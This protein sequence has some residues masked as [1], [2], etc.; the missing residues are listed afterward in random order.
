[1]TN[2]E[3]LPATSTIKSTSAPSF[4]TNF[5]LQNNSTTTLSLFWIDTQGVERPYGT[6]Q[7]GASLY[8]ST[9]STHAWLVRDEKNTVLFKF[10]ASAS[11]LV[12]VSAS[13][14]TFQANLM[15][16]SGSD[17]IIGTSAD[18]R[19]EPG[20]GNDSINGGAGV[21]LVRLP[22]ISKDYEIKLNST[23]ES[24]LFSSGTFG[25]KT[26]S[27]VEY[28]QF[29]DDPYNRLDLNRLAPLLSYDV[30][31]LRKTG[32]SANR[33]DIVFVAEGYTAGQRQQFLA[34]AARMAESMLGQ[35]NSRL[36]GPFSAY[37]GLFNVTAIFVPSAQ[38]GVD[39]HLNGTLVDT[40]FD[41]RTYGTDGRLGYG[42]QSRVNFVLD[43]AVSI[44]GRDM[45]VV[46]MNTA[47]YTNAGG[48]SA[49]VSASNPGAYDL[50][51][52]E[53]GH[54]YA[55]LED[56]YVDA[57]LSQGPLPTVLNS[58][59]V[60]LSPTTVPWKLW[61]GYQDELGTIGAYEG[62]Y[63]RKTGVWRATLTSKMLATGQPFSAPQKEAF[64]E[65][66]Y[67][68][69]GDYLGLSFENS[70]S[71]SAVVPDLIPVGLEWQS[72]GRV[73]GVGSMLDAKAL[74]SSGS[75][76]LQTPLPV[77]VTLSSKDASGMI[78]DPGILVSTYQTETIDVLLGG[79]DNDKFY[80]T[81]KSD[82][83]VA[84]E[85]DDN[86][87]GLSGDDVLYGND[88][89]D[90]LSGG[91]GNDTL[92]GGAGTDTALYTGP[93]ANY[94]LA[95]LAVG[96]SIFSK[97]EGLDTL[98]SIERLK[99]FDCSLA[100]D[101]GVPQSAGETA[102]LIGAVL[103]GKLALDVSKQALLGSV[104]GLFD[105]GYSM[106]TLAGAL[107]RLDIWSILTGQP[108]KTAA[109]T[110]A[111]DTAIVKY[112]LSNVYGLVADEATVKANA[113]VMHNEAS[114]GAWLAQLAQSN[115]GQSHI[116]LMGLASTGLVYA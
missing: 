18:D 4:T 40:A 94:A 12:K 36:N 88:G 48:A 95:P 109:R 31:Q 13:N 15:G 37:A 75:P 9:W 82:I 44:T 7:A 93:K 27:G 84:G 79:R 23:V 80:A 76:V 45:V 63:Y 103:P 72:Q 91:T 86:I 3:F 106:P 98:G 89:Q 58:V 114:Q 24:F 33:V 16:T 70:D 43:R 73:V 39:Q 78:R 22:G 5:E 41:A 1:M 92:N 90:T 42:D 56:E 100:L 52:H 29:A 97:A 61:L 57:A 113:D 17:L 111:E 8:Q 53:I 110:L 38:S 116:G 59:H 19:F 104:I 50:A 77:K 25:N 112:L 34:D 74:A 65:Q 81:E 28:V 2:F 55:G 47:I 105:A 69:V 30:T 101:L 11:G 107:L 46:L 60:S 67:K 83:V 26:L 14:S 6:V 96:F 20:T 35:P 71:P 102:L 66:F 21:D 87:M 85:G 51:L 115:A 99:F 32:D 49:W 68:Q 64:I 10:V 62:G 54:S 108:V